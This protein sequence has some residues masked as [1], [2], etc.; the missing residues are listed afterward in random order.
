[1]QHDL[2]DVAEIF[3][4]LNQG[5]TRV[6]EADVTVALVAAANPGWV[7]EEF[8]TYAHDLE[9][10]GYDLEP[11]IF[12]RTITGI[13][14][15]TARLKDVP[16]DFWRP[17]VTANWGRVKATMNQTLQLMKDRGV[18]SSQI[19]PSRNSLIPLF[20]IQDR[21]GTSMSFDPVFR[22]FLLA[23]ADGRYS[24]SATTSLTQDLNAIYNAPTVAVA[25]DRLMGELRIS[26]YFAPERFLEDYSRDRF[27]RLLVYLL[28]FDN[29][30]TDWVSKVRENRF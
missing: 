26:D 23:N 1:M 17:D 29:A 6:T 20:A 3:A 2:E 5:G 12:I 25:L 22:W 8:L 16:L 24:G 11:G 13:V 27:G 7:S 10:S 30:A 4:R 14:H 28:I 21:F 15:G 18:L 19:L 9:E